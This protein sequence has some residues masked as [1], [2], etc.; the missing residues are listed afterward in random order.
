M[1]ETQILCLDPPSTGPFTE[2]KNKGGTIGFGRKVMNS[3]LNFWTLKC[4]CD[5]EVAIQ[6][7]Q[8]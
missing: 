2:V 1:R 5:S 6:S 4:L 8:F 3:V 7:R